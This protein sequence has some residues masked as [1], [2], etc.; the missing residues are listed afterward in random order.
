MHRFER[1]VFIPAVFA[2]E[3]SDAEFAAV[4]EGNLDGRQEVFR[5]GVPFLGDFDEGRKVADVAEFPV[6]GKEGLDVE[7]VGRTG[8]GQPVAVV[9]DEHGVIFSRP[10]VEVDP[11]RLFGYVAED[12]GHAMRQVADFFAEAD[13]F[14]DVIGLVPDV[15]DEV[16]GNGKFREDDDVT[17]GC[18]GLGD[19]VLHDRR[20]LPRIA[21]ID[22]GLGECYFKQ[23][24]ASFS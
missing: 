2:D 22:P 11:V 23:G 20:V 14:V 10:A 8:R 19:E 1:I 24:K 5:E 6:I 13:A 9:G 18:L 4:V 3:G 12:D 7:G 16:A 15:A 17:A 21:G